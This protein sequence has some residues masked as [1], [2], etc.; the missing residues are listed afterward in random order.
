VPQVL[1]IR[2]TGEPSTLDPQQAADIASTSIVRNLFSSLLR[3]DEQQQVQPDLARE[4]P[5]AENGGV[6]EDGLTYTFKLRAGLQWSDGTA[7]VARDFVNAAQRLFAPGAGNQFA[8]FYRMIAAGGAQT[9]LDE[10]QANDVEGDALVA[11]EQAVVDNLEVSAPDD[12]TVVYR[13]N[14]P[15]P[16]FTVLATLWPLAP[17]P[18]H[19]IDEHGDAWTEPGNLVSSGPFTLAEW[20]HT[21]SLTLV[22]N[23][24][25]H[26]DGPTLEEVRF[27]IIGDDAIAFLAY[28]GDELDVVTLGPAELVQVRGGELEDEFQSYALLSTVGVFFNFNTPVLQD[29]K[30]R[31]ALAGSFDR[32]EFAEIVSEGAVLPAYSYLPPGM[33]GHDPQAGLQFRDATARSQELLSEAGYPGGEGLAITLLGANVGGSVTRAEWLKEQW[34]R[35][36]GVTVEL[37]LIE[38]SSFIEKLFAGDWDLI[39][40]SWTADYPDPQDWLPAF[41]PGGPLAVGGFE[42]DRFT[43]LLEEAASELDPDRRLERYLEAQRILIDDVAFSPVFYVRRNILVKPWVEGFIT[44]ATDGDVPGEAFLDRVSISERP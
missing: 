25:W 39:S 15:S 41:A 12:L 34:E 28:R 33:A 30:V 9:A 43:A 42:D 17:V 31:Q 24:L 38:P 32:D 40:G 2:M 13:L 10:A 1:R 11:L 18:Q 7:I 44:S 36:L 22:R 27:D 6:S 3:I 16:V 29:P 14:A 20:D 8:D 21:V 23:E 5:T 4:V 26:G 19:V 35:N 37:D